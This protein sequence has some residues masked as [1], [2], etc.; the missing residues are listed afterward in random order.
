MAERARHTDKR[1][2][3]SQ[4]L[5]RGEDNLQAELDQDEYIERVEAMRRDVEK[6]SRMANADQEFA[7]AA[8]AATER[9]DQEQATNEAGNP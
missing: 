5:R 4:R 2:G 9:R 8:L 6:G 7:E 1:P 3:G